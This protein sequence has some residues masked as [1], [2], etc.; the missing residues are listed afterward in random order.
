MCVCVCGVLH[1]A[2]AIAVCLLPFK[3]YSGCAASMLRFE[4]PQVTGRPVLH[5]YLNKPML[6]LRTAY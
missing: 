6:T 3:G 2:V 4:R 1:A 5:E